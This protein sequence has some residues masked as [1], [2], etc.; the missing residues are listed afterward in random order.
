MRCSSTAMSLA[1]LLA[2]HL[3][4]QLCLGAATDYRDLAAA[5]P[6]S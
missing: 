5:L 4:R 6:F 3:Q 2:T 1:E